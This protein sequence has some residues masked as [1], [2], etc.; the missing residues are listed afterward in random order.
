MDNS[1]PGL[2]TCENSYNPTFHLT[3]VSLYHNL[4]E[5]LGGGLTTGAAH[6]VTVGT[7]TIQ[8]GL[9][10]EKEQVFI[11]NVKVDVYKEGDM[12]GT[13]LYTLEGT[14]NDK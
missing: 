10:L 2:I 5:N 12:G 1:I 7:S 9:S 4:K 11:Y 8:E 13:L 3:N 14:K 6:V